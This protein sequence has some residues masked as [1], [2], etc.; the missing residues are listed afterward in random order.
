[1]PKGQWLAARRH[2]IGASEISAVLGISPWDS[3]FSLWYRKL[4]GWQVADSPEMEA[5]RRAEPMI[6]DWF[7]DNHPGFE[8]CPGGLWANVHRPWQIASP[9]RRLFAT[10]RLW[11][12]VLECKTAF[13]WEGW[14]ESGT[15]DIPVHYQAQV[16]W[17]M[18]VMGVDT[19]FVAAFAGLEFREYIIKRDEK[20]LVMM[21]ERGRRFWQS[22]LDGEPPDLDDHPA[23]LSV[24]RQMHPDI[25]DRKQ[26]VPEGV[27]RNWL[28]AKQY[29]SKAARLEAKYS[30]QMRAHMG[31]ARQ[32]I[33]QGVLVASRSIDDKL[34]VAGKKEHKW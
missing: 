17:Q 12:G 9:D 1:M 6:A 32:A 3:P 31:D 34:M 25:V 23:T 22:L 30:A 7:A 20:T 24:I 5:G 14:G 28:R 26:A 15:D 19:A 16:L 8:V 4:H 33:C 13:S 21:R 27:V 18:D 2:G 10:K 11:R 29:K